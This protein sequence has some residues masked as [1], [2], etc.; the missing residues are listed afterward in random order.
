MYFSCVQGMVTMANL[1]FHMVNGKAQTSD[2]VGKVLYR[3]F[4]KIALDTPLSK[5]SR[6]L[7]TDHFVIVVH[8]QKQCK[9]SIKYCFCF[10]INVGFLFILMF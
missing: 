6:I 10:L 5:V 2:P 1:M 8:T 7:E 4:R 9:Y 3:Q